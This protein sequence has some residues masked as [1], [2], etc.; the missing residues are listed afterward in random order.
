M[1]VILKEIINFVRHSRWHAFFYQ[2]A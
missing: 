2:P 1:A